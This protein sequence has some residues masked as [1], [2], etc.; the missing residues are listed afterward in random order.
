M[1]Y[2]SSSSPSRQMSSW[3]G[4][5]V[6][7]QRGKQWLCK[8]FDY[9]TRYFLVG[10]KSLVALI[11]LLDSF[12]TIC[13][14]RTIIT[15]SDSSPNDDILEF[16]YNLKLIVI[17][18][19]SVETLSNYCRPPSLQLLSFSS[20]FISENKIAAGSTLEQRARSSVDLNEGLSD[21][22]FIRR[23]EDWET[24]RL[25]FFNGP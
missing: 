14:K 22:C 9:K 8:S 18:S 10:V 7:E 11:T 1:I 19:I 25:S 6:E 2:E 20:I 17:F 5:Q 23:H 16:V 13:L 4:D 12:S 24:W 15:M 3:C 21:T